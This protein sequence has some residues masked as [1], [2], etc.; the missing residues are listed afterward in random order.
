MKKLSL[1]IAMLMS[2]GILFNVYADDLGELD[3]LLNQENTTSGN[4]TT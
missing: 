4:T 1:I 3:S 2:A